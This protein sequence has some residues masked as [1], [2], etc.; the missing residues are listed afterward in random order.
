[1]KILTTDQG[2]PQATIQN[3]T[4]ERTGCGLSLNTAMTITKVS[5]LVIALANMPTADAGPIAYGICA[6]ACGTT[7]AVLSAGIA[8]PPAIAAC[9]KACLSMYFIPTP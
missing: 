2:I 7:V 5:L 3:N 8:L 1:M 9:M 4:R 6:A